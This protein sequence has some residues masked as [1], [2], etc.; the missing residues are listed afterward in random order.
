MLHI[1]LFNSAELILVSV[2]VGGALLAGKAGHSIGSI[3]V[4]VVALTLFCLFFMVHGN[5]A[6]A[7]KPPKKRQ[8]EQPMRFMVVRSA[9]K[10][11]E[12]T[13]PEWISAEGMITGASPKLFKQVLASLGGR[14]LPVIITSPGGDVSAAMQIGELIRTNGLDAGVGRTVLMECGKSNVN[15]SSEKERG[16]LHLGSVATF[17]GYCASACPLMLAGGIKRFVG[18]SAI[19]GLH[20]VTTTSRQLQIQYRIT[21]RIVGGKKRII[22][23]REVGRR[24]LPG[25]TY[26]QMSAEQESRIAAYLS[27]QGVVEWQFLSMMK[28]AAAS[29]LRVLQQSEMWKMGLLTGSGAAELLVENGLC[30]QVPAAANCRVVTWADVKKLA[31]KAK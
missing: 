30:N 1:P 12:P 10:A 23:K 5:V 17:G 29:D 14:R 16:A 4:R 24:I 3:V 31:G 21:Y 6:E 25:E 22:S 18:P 8:A 9:P 15:C 2:V 19:V 28:E 13:C 26:Y 27:L 11:C 20:Q 7:A